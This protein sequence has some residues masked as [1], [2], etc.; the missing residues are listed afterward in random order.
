M[1]PKDFSMGVWQGQGTAFPCTPFPKNKP[2]PFTQ[3]NRRALHCMNANSSADY[4][5][6]SIDLKL[7][8]QNI[9]TLPKK[10][11]TCRGIV[12]PRLWPVLLHSFAFLGQTAGLQPRSC[13]RLHAPGGHRQVIAC[14]RALLPVLKQSPAVNN[15]GRAEIPEGR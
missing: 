8:S 13:F 7:L 4:S 12:C 9:D 6:S 15:F 14:C 5:A 11:S 3:R 10:L 1:K 2:W